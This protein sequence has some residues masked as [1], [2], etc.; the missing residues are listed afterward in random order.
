VHDAA[1]RKIAQNSLMKGRM[2]SWLMGIITL[3]GRKPCPAKELIGPYGLADPIF[4]QV[5]RN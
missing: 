3:R 5:L 4:R 1:Q 2:P